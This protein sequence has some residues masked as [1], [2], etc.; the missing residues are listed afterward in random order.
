M[1]TKP[2]VTPTEPVEAATPAPAAPP[3]PVPVK[4]IKPAKKPSTA[5]VDVS[6]ELA[7]RAAMI[8]ATEK[9]DGVPYIS[10]KGGAF[11]FQDTVLDN[12]MRVILLDYS[13]INM[14][15]GA[16]YDEDNPQPPTC[17]A[18]I[19]QGEG[20]EDQ[21][22]PLAESPE[23]Q[24]DKCA[25]CPQNVFGTDIRGKGKAC[26]NQRRLALVSC[27]DGAELDAL[28]EGSDVAYLRVP[29]A[30]LSNFRKYV[31]QLAKVKGLPPLGVITD[32]GIQQRGGGHEIT[33]DFVADVPKE[34]LAAML[35]LADGVQDQLLEAPSFEAREA[36][37]KAKPMKK[38]AAKVANKPAKFV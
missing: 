21:M 31:K 30:S 13:L 11:K 35:K 5:L 24:A 27:R 20:A 32:I 6:Q 14:Y 19:T 23:K 38:P 2:K 18:V 7:R 9:S 4:V 25:D 34:K 17:V 1:P 16:M 8:Q 10:T 26:K 33:F 28:S 37:P 15:Y 12:P 3:K 36:R 29:P 22:A